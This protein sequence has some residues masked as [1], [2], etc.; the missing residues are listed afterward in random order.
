MMRLQKFLSQAGVA[1]RRK[2]EELIIQGKIEVNGRIVT[3]LGS[4]VDEKKDII[5][6]NGQIVKSST[7]KV[8]IALNKPAGYAN[9]TSSQQGKSVLEL[10]KVQEKI[11]PIGRMDKDVSGLTILTND[12]EFANK[13]SHPYYG[14]EKEY[15]VVLNKDLQAEDIKKL[16]RGVT[17]SGKKLQGIKVVMAKNKSARLILK[18]GINNQIKR[19]MGKFGYDVKKLKVIRIGKLELENILEGKWKRIEKSSIF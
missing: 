10:V 1:S 13:I 3:K 4:T 7:E 2:A 8:Y 19:S 18:E 11:Y 16:E 5:K 6:Y 14:S 15:F 12:G 9:S 17:L